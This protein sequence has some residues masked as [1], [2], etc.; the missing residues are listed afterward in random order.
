M[1]ID[2]INLKRSVIRLYYADLEEVMDGAFRRECP[3]CLEGI[4]PL[5]RDDDGKLMSTDR[6]I[7]C[8]QRVQYMD[9]G[10]ED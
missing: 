6:C 3:F 7:G 10:I 5:H 9:I 1:K 4:L 2:P 8:G